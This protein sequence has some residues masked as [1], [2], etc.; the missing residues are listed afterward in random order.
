MLAVRRTWPDAALFRPA[1]LRGSG[2]DDSPTLQ[3]FSGLAP[4]TL[5]RTYRPPAAG[6]AL[7]LALALAPDLRAQP[8]SSGSGAGTGTGM[9]GGAARNSTGTG[10]ESG[11]GN[12]TG[13][14]NESG[15]GLLLPGSGNYFG[16]SNRRGRLLSPDRIPGG[17]SIPMGPGATTN[18]PG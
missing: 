4:M 17:A 2:L 7:A 18:Y 5:A 10:L 1:R 11:A 16:P 8:L 6:L 15:A 13:T 9:S 12:A 14:G 3:A